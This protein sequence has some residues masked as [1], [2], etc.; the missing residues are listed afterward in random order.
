MRVGWKDIC[1]ELEDVFED[2][3]GKDKSE[4]KF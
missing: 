2:L 4:V 1:L 3:S